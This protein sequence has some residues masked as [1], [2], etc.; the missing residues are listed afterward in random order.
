MGIQ[1]EIHVADERIQ[2]LSDPAGGLFDAAG[3]FD[4]LVALG[5]PAL[6]LLGQIDPH[7]ETRLDASQ[8]PQL[9]AEVELLLVQATASAER[10]GLM[11]LR[12]LAE[13]CVHEQGELV[14]VGD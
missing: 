7:G 5:N 4:R 12:A 6:R 14:L 8:M 3:D 11:R 9:V 13:R 2:R 10:R 1:V